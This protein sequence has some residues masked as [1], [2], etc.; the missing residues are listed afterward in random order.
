MKS[1]VLHYYEQRLKKKNQRIPQTS[2]NKG[3]AVSYSGRPE[4]WGK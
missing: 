1:L 2:V 4:I 3:I